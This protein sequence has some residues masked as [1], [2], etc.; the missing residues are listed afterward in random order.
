MA[1]RPRSKRTTAQQKGKR[2]DV[3]EPE[4][5]GLNTSSSEGV[6]ALDSDNLDDDDAGTAKLRKNTGAKRKKKPGPAKPTKRR[7][8][9]S[10]EEEES[11]LELKQG[12]EV[13]GKIV[14]A[15]KTGQGESNRSDRRSNVTRLCSSSRADLPEHVR[16]SEP[17]HGAGVQRS[18]MVRSFPVAS[19]N[20]RPLT[21]AS[22]IQVQIKWSTCSRSS[23]LPVADRSN[24]EP[25]FRQAEKEWKAFIEVFTDHVVEA[26]AQIPHLPPRDVI[27]RIYRDVSGLQWPGPAL[28]VFFRPRFASATTR[29]RTKPTFRPPF[30]GAAERASSRTV[31]VP[32]FCVFSD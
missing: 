25:V 15:P 13:V 18:G 1:P 22:V 32:F 27:H 7:K 28:T 14:R 11:E 12:Q 19:E 16:I 21:T 2:R 4:D 30:P 26:D 3:S 20:F 9:A 8:K 23:P 29:P 31:R 24:A 10:S 6:E 17:A 5:E